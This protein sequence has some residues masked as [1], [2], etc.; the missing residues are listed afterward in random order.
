MLKVR[1]PRLTLA[2]IGFRVGTKASAVILK[3]VIR[4]GTMRLALHT[5]SV[6]GAWIGMISKVPACDKLKLFCRVV[7]EGYT[8]ISR[9]AIW[10][11]IPFCNVLGFWS[12]N[13]N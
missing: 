2:R 8:I 4:A 3:S 12:A 10:G 1:M 11:K 13:S 9:A 7:L 6:N 5:N